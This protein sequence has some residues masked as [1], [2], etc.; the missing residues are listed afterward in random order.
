MRIPHKQPTSV[1]TDRTLPCA[2]RPA[3]M[4]DANKNYGDGMPAATTPSTSGPRFTLRE[5]RDIREAI[6]ATTLPRVRSRR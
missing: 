1:E 4:G 2:A 5:L 3:I 6:A